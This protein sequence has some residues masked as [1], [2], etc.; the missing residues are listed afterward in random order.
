MFMEATD[1]A[2]GQSLAWIPSMAGNDL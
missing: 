1:F 2:G